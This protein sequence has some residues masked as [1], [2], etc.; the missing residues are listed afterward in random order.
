MSVELDG[1]ADYVLLVDEGHASHPDIPTGAELRPLPLG[2]GS[3]AYSTRP[4]RDLVR[5]VRAAEGFDVLLFPSLVTW[6]PTRGTPSVVGL[7]DASR[8][9]Q[10]GDYVLLDGFNGFLVVNPT[11]QTTI[12]HGGGTVE[13]PT[14]SGCIQY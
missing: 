9:L 10:S 7:H 5:L 13:R 14:R 6:F 1:D 2:R 4:M 12:A 3:S 8:H 11:D